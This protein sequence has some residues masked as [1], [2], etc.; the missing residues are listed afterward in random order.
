MALNEFFDVLK[1]EKKLTLHYY[2]D[3]VRALFM[4][5]ALVMI[6]TLPFVYKLL[7]VPLPVSILI[8]LFLGIFAALTNPL[9][10]SSVIINAFF[11]IGAFLV[12]EYFAIDA[13][14]KYTIIN[15]LFWTNQLLSIIFLFAI[16][17][18]TK[19]LRGMYLRKTSQEQSSD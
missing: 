2:G 1:T 11:S 13:Y 4:L 8:I 9:Q 17:Y 12:F 10:I 16:Y 19:T 5:A 3:M 15:L 7:P 6:I 18:S 14:I